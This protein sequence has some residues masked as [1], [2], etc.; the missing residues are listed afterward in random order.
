MPIDRQRLANV[1][2]LAW[3]RSGLLPWYSRMILWSHLTG[4]PYRHSRTCWM[5]RAVREG[6]QREDL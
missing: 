3:R 6:V 5:M 2:R 1:R 4:R